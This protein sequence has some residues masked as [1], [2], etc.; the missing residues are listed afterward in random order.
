MTGK[1]K[2]LKNL[3]QRSQK[4]LK[5]T[6]I[7]EE[8]KHQVLQQQTHSEELSTTIGVKNT[9]VEDLQFARYQGD[10]EAIMDRLDQLNVA[11]EGKKKL[12]TKSSTEKI[13]RK[14]KVLDASQKDQPT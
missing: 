12:S 4:V 5:H 13:H 9:E 8:M 1:W 7:Q 3:Q 2:I 14:M 11:E 10:L 6:W